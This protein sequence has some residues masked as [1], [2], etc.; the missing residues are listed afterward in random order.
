MTVF[1]ETVIL[2]YVLTGMHFVYDMG[3][4]LAWS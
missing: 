2:A 3:A 4:S 1:M